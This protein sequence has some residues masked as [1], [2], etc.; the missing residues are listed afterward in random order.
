MSDRRFL[1]NIN[2]DYSIR[3]VTQA[4]T[5]TRVLERLFK[6]FVSPNHPP[7]PIVRPDLDN[8][9]PIACSICGLFFT[10]SGQFAGKRCID[11]GH[12]QAAGII[13]V[14]DYYTMAKIKA[15]KA[16]EQ[17]SRPNN[18]LTDSTP[19]NASV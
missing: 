14:K 10:L 17:L 9:E 19:F 18:S 2:R 16:N 5:L 12:W 6:A 7:T 8:T 11:P 15:A 1:S 3:S 13:T 4:D